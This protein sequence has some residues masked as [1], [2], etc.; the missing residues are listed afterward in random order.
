MNR[1]LNKVI[2]ITGGATGIGQ[3]ACNLLARE[4]AVIALVDI[5]DQAGKQTVA[6]LKAQESKAEFWH[7]DVTNES[8]VER[9]FNDIVKKF[10]RI[11]VLVNNA[12]F[13]GSNKPT[14]EVTE[15]EW[16]KVMNINAKGTFFCTKHAI[17]HLKN[18]GGGSIIN[19]SSIHGLLGSPDYPANHA[20][21]GAI[22][23]MSKTDAMI[24][25]K[26]KIRVNSIHPGYIQTPCLGEIPPQSSFDQLQALGHLG[27]AEDIA[28]GI[29]YLASDESKFVTASELVI[30][31][32]IF[33]GRLF[34]G[35]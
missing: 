25:A 26:D 32:G 34:P 5:N 35:C 16:D 15:A 29:L 1:V 3:A 21:K 2:I 4:G 8:E 24:Y 23:L 30:D 27:E 28:Y 11:D 18:K 12:G 13:I 6:A 7:M 9:V 10:G 20:S 31:G 14:H 17:A 22:R 19:I 33:G